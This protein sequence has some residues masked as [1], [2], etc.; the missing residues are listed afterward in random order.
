MITALAAAWLTLIVASYVPCAGQSAA[1]AASLAPRPPPASQGLTRASAGDGDSEAEVHPS[2]RTPSRPGRA[3]A[4]GTCSRGAA[5][6]PPCA[7]LSHRPQPCAPFPANSSEQARCQT[8]F[9]CHQNNFQQRNREVR[10]S[11][12]PFSCFPSRPPEAC[13]GV[14][15]CGR[16]RA[17][18]PMPSSSSYSLLPDCE[19]NT[20][21][22]WRPVGAAGRASVQCGPGIGQRCPSPS[23]CPGGGG[24]CASPHLRF[25]AVKHVW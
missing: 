20:A 7:L 3:A 12:G 17:P 2:A 15:S 8:C 10:V 6:R 5:T 18:F 4:P 23:P 1:R 22:P 14:P 16:E 11:S 25:L 21:F 19:L 24:C 9:I 13:I